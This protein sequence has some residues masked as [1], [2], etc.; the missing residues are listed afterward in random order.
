MTEPHIQPVG[1]SALV[2]T[3]GEEIS[4]DINR[5]V[6]ALVR[7]VARERLAGIEECVPTYSTLLV[8]YDPLQWRYAQVRN[9][10]AG[11]VREAESSPVEP[12]RRIE[13]PTRY[14]GP[15]LEFVARHHH[16][17]IEDVIRIH[18]SGEY[19]VYMMGF[20][21]GFPYLG[22][23]DDSI[24]TPR[25][26]TPRSHVPAGSVGIA[27]R[28]TGIYP[29]D[30]PGGWRV[31]GHTPRRLFDPTETPPFLLAPGNV[32]RFVPI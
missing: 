22:T 1:D 24:A 29:V 8:H 9:W 20:T 32:V 23:L 15:D 26:E 19:L 7:L 2:V 16:L 31:I 18:S 21:P 25:L 27:G 14:D 11:Q 5:R 3:F 13:I 28:Q 10:L 12:P 4:L 30:S 6:Q 17:A